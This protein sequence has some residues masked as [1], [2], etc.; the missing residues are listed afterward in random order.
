MKLLVA[1]DTDVV[2]GCHMVSHVVC[3]MGCT[4]SECSVP[5]MLWGS[6]LAPL[7]AGLL[8]MQA[9]CAAQIDWVVA[10]LVLSCRWAPTRRR[11]CR[12]S[13]WR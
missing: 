11:S 7:H 12:A 13:A 6:P 8:H 1:A 9:L 4:L 5:G 2:V 10:C 3:S